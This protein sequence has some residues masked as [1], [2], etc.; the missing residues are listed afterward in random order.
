M[1]LRLAFSVAVHVEPRIL[2]I[3]EI[4]AVGDVRFMQKCLERIEELK[5]DGVTILLTSHVMVHI[6]KLADR[7]V[8]LANGVVRGQGDTEEI[9]E[10]YESVMIEGL[11]EPEPLPEGGMRVGTKKVEIERVRLLGP[12]AAPAQSLRSAY[13][14]TIEVDYFAHERVEK[15][16]FGIGF[17]PEGGE[18]LAMD[19]DTDSDHFWIDEVEGHGTVKLSIERL[20]L[21]AGEYLL[22]VGIYGNEWGEVYDYL[23]EC[24][25]FTVEAET[26]KGLVAPPRK[27]EVR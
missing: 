18:T 13:P 1:R 8:W 3:D 2:L 11:P 24:R 21:A 22:D 17:H 9:V 27:W 14:A 10:R 5:Q 16:I 25:S 7:V 26:N 4:L 19:L 15:P 12:D 23:W 20:D 6:R